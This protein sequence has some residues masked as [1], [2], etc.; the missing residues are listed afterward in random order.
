MTTMHVKNP[1]TGNVTQ[2]EVTGPEDPRAVILRQRLKR[3]DLESASAST[4]PGS[5]ADAPADIDQGVK[6]EKGDW[7]K[8][9]HG[10]GLDPDGSGDALGVPS[11]SG[12]DA[13]QSQKDA[14]VAAREVEKQAKAAEKSG[15][16]LSASATAAAEAAKSAK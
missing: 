2:F 10:G 13:G 6:D 16:K 12:V 5:P 9:V 1:R 14:E 8:S 15:Q 7:L 4:K 3:G 11:G